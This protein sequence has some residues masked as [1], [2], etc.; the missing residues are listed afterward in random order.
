MCQST[1]L[2][3]CCSLLSF[4]SI[5]GR[6]RRLFFLFNILKSL[7]INSEPQSIKPVQLPQSS[8]THPT[9]CS[10]QV[11]SRSELLSPWLPPSQS[12]T[13]LVTTTVL[14]PLPTFLAVTVKT[15]SSPKALAPKRL[16]HA[17]LLSEEPQLSPD[18][19]VLIVAL[20]TLSHTR[21]SASMF[22]QSTLPSRASTSL[23]K[24][25]IR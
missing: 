2:A 10:S 4:W 7:I 3:K 1:T 23:K 17:S 24:R 25:W 19:T 8:H 18:G 22:S 21:E 12:L 16:S 14:V 9:E 11:S 13:T 5:R 20:A 6:E 15:A